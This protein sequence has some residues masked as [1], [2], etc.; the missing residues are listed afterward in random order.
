LLDS[1]EISDDMRVTL[2]KISQRLAKTSNLHPER[3][4]LTSLKIQDSWPVDSGGFGDVYMA[5]VSSHQGY[6]REAILWGQLF[7]PNVLPF[8]G[9]SFVGI[10]P[11]IC[12]VSPWME[13][14][15]ITT[16]LKRK[17]ANADPVKIM[18]DISRGLKYLHDQK[19]VH[20]DLKG[21]RGLIQDTTI[22]T[23]TLP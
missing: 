9:I 16:F 6:A 20:G 23:M 10:P 15:N 7:H 17:N 4:V 2:I 18:S 21:V 3:L 19:V 1:C 8:Y 22:C 11:R 12:L 13:N 5:S 14:G